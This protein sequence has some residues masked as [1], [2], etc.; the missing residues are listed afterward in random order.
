M[1]QKTELSIR[2]AARHIWTPLTCEN[3]GNALCD[4]GYCNT[5]G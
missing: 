5:E 4:C 1:A 3:Y 2:E